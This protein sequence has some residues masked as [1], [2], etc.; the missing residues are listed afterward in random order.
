MTDIT[1]IR[2]YWADKVEDWS[3]WADPMAKL[4]SG[5]NKPLL[6]ELNI[7]SG[8]MVLDLASGVGEPIFSEA[9][10]VG[11][12]GLAVATDLVPEMLDALKNRSGSDIMGFSAADMQSLPFNDK[13]F[14]HVSCRFGIMF[15]PDQQRSIDEC[16]RV[17]KSKGK[18]AYLVW[19]AKKNQR[20]FTIMETSILNLFNIEVDHDFDRI[21]SL[22]DENVLSGMLIKSGFDIL[23]NRQIHFKPIAPIGIRFWQS[24]LDM[25]FGHL[26]TG[27][28]AE[29]LESLHQ[30]IERNLQEFQIKNSGY[31]MA[32][33]VRLVCGQ[34]P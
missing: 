10:L 11:H 2:N 7:Q 23:E 25:S 26:L 31:Q 12:D 27:C 1:N 13:V 30:E 5:M 29:E 9:K 33:D 22:H 28:S 19:G 32:L 17:L 3:Q 18:A 24:Q 14:D 34:K 21:F 15:V 16:F 4:A 8:D 20:I 6:N